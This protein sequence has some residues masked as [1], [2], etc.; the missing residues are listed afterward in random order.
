MADDKKKEAAPAGEEGEE[1]KKGGNL[2]LVIAIIAGILIIQT[3]IA[4]VLALSLKPEDPEKVAARA[5]EQAYRDSVT[6][7]TRVGAFTADEPI[8]VVVNIAGTDAERLLKAGIV[9]EYDAKNVALGDELR[10][11]VPRY[12]DMLI[13][14]LSAQTLMELTGPGAQDRIRT[15]LLRQINASLPPALGEVQNVAIHN[16]IIQ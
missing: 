12:R 11:R 1:K 16:F 15:D 7:A 5:A 4:F 14:Y 2:I 3:G 13:S 10:R 9:L 8:E 6:A